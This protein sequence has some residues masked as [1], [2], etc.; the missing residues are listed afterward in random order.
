MYTDNRLAIASLTGATDRES[1]YVAVLERGGL[2]IL[3]V[4]VGVGDLALADGWS[5]SSTGAA[6]ILSRARQVATLSVSPTS[7]PASGG[8]V[9]A[10]LTLDRAIDI[11]T[12]PARSSL[13]YEIRAAYAL[14]GLS[15]ALEVEVADGGTSSTTA[16]FTVP[17]NTTGAAY[18]VPFSLVGPGADLAAPVHVSVAG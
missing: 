15:Q 16:T 11:A 17:A 4:E 12:P 8:E 18:N 6:T 14:L 2:G 10:S 1:G 7:L 9:A 13:A 5:Y 3:I